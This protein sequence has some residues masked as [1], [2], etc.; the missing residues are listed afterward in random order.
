MIV[1]SPRRSQSVAGTLVA[2][3]RRAADMIGDLIANMEAW[4]APE[5]GL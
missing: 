5:L 2:S 3:A 1:R 4:G